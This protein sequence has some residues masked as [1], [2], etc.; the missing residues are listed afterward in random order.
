[1]STIP[2]TDRPDR[3][4]GT[5]R[6]DRTDGTDEHSD[7]VLTPRDVRFDWDRVPVHWVPGEPTA[8]HVIN[9]LHMLLP[10]GERWFV[11]VFQQAVPLITDEELRERVLGFTGQ[12]AMH[13]EAHQGVLDHFVA[14]GIDI[15]PY[16]AQV[17]Y[18]FHH[19]LGDKEGLSPQRE[20]EYLIE[21]VA[22]IAGIEHFT[23]FLG[24]W[25]LN[26]KALDR[27][28]ADAIM[29]DLL[30]WHGAEEVEHRS[31]AYDLLR[32]LDPGYLRRA[33]TMVVSITALLQ[34]WVRGTR[35][36]LAVDPELAGSVEPSVRTAWTAARRGLLPNPV[37]LGIS[38]LRYFSRNYHPSQEGSTRQAIAYLGAS[39]AARAAAH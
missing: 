16:I 26:A 23:A 12:E 4:D 13:A 24:D 30:R 31:V 5:D 38:A 32:H 14:K 15:G 7:L 19:L 2:P 25:I 33:R 11:R 21:R 6:N 34:L 1:M 36:L 37:K 35:F 39:P 22:I 27:A 29:L 10:E 18:L 28:G 3:T 8:T 20:R 17:E 9:V